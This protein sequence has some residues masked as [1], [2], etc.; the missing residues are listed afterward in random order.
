ML[1]GAGNGHTVQHLKEVE[2]Q[3]FQQS[4]CGSFLC[5]ALAPR[6]KGLL[7]TAENFI[8]RFGCIQLAVNV[9]GVALI[10]KGKLV[11]QVIEPVVDRRG[12][13]HQNL[14]LDACTHHTIHK[15]QVAVFPVIFTGNI[16]AVAEVMAFIDHNQVIVA[17]VDTRKIDAVGLAP[18]SRQVCVEQ[19]IIPQSVSGNGVVG[20]VAFICIPVLR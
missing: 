20:V 1:S 5:G 19:H 9:F 13:E 4:I 16:A 8:N 12:R 6:V 7:R 2:V 15:T 17:P 18:I 11:F 14:G 10:C 3:C